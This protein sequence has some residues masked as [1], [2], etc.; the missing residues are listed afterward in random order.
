MSK[1]AIRNLI[2]EG[3]PLE[4]GL[5]GALGG[6]TGLGL[7]RVFHA[8][9]GVVTLAAI[10]GTLL[11]AGIFAAS[12]HRAVRRVAEPEVRAI[13]ETSPHFALDPETAPIAVIVA[14]LRHHLGTEETAFISGV[15]SPPLVGRWE[16]G[17]IEPEPLPRARLRFG[18]KTVRYIVSAYDGETARAWLFGTNEWLR[19]E[20]P[21]GVLR[22]G[23]SPQDWIPV[24]EA[25]EAFVEF[26]R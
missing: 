13:P 18:F 24:V 9:P 21:I 11:G 5:A 8:S 2:L 26:V 25:A 12:A 16:S 7:G 3:A 6:A 4:L 17:T 14:Y 22:E 15:D 23:Q 19:D 20:A 10:G 1:M